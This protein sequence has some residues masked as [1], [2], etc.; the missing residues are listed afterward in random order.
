MSEGNEEVDGNVQIFNCTGQPA[1]LSTGTGSVIY[2]NF[3][4]INNTGPCT[5]EEAMVGGAVQVLSNA[6]PSPTNIEA[7]QIFGN[8]QCQ[9]TARPLRAVA[10]AVAVAAAIRSMEPNKTSV[11]ASN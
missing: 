1:F 3:Q 9:K 8:L 11:S 10:V 6:T 5:L 4:C 7:D 2:G